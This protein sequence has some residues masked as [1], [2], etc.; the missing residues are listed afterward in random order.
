M[1]AWL[2]QLE[3]GSRCRKWKMCWSKGSGK[4]RRRK[5]KVFDGGKRDANAALREFEE[6]C[7]ALPEGD[8]SFEGFAKRWNDG[9]L[10][11]NAIQEVT[12][13]KYVVAIELFSRMLPERLAD[14]EPKDVVAAYAALSSGE[15]A[16]R[17]AWSGTSLRTAHNALS[18]IF[19]AAQA[20]GLVASNPCAKVDPPKND[21]Q[22]RRALSPSQASELMGRLGTDD[23]HEFAVS[24]ILRTGMRPG[25]CTGVLWG[26]VSDCV[27]VRRECT[28][29]DAGVRSIPLDRASVAYIAERRRRVDGFLSKT[30]DVLTGADALCCHDDGRPL[31]YNALRRWWSRHRADYGLDGWVLHE[32][33]HTYITNLAQAKVHPTVMSRLAGHSRS[34]L[35]ME[36]YTHV[37]SDD[38]RDAVAALAKARKCDTKCDTKPLDEKTRPDEF[39]V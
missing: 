25:E 26:D 23:A 24:M 20:E 35:A 7:E 38:M 30:G 15:A 37:N 31:T 11:S 22:K 39:A 12:H 21:T 34:S 18:R 2:E 8:E 32:L 13:A 4:V 33:R 29:T 36:V 28:K 16:P 14:V 9:R 3:E 1:S 19:S 5:F 10:G 6:E 27:D 17:R